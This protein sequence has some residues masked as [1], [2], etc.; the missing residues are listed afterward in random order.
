MYDPSLDLATSIQTVQAAIDACREQI[1][2]AGYTDSNGIT[3]DTA[4]S[5]IQNLSGICTLIACGAVTS[6]QIWRDANNVNHTMT[7]AQLVTLAGEIAL[8]TA[9]CYQ[10]AWT[11][12]TNVSALTSILDVQAYDYS[13]GWPSN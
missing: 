8:F 7:P 12:K 1:M 13:T 2:S 6:N 4:S 5:D 10:N 11:H 3:W 9:Q